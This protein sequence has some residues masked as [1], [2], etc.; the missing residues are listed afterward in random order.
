MGSIFSYSLGSGIF[1]LA[2]FI[3]YRLLLAS[4]KQPSLNRAAL[5]GLYAA[6]LLALPAMTLARQAS[7]ALP[8]SG[9]PAVN[10]GDIAIA[11]AGTP[12][13]PSVL[14]RI[15]LWTYLAGAAAILLHT[16]VS[17]ARLA[18]LIRSGRHIPRD[19]YTLVTLPGDIVPFSFAGYIVMSEADALS[20]NSMITAHELGH[21]R[22]RHWLDLLLAQGVCA[23]MWYNPAAWLARRELRRVHEYQADTAVLDRGAN[24]RAYQ[25]L[26]IEKAAGVRLQSIANSLDHSNLSKRITMMYKQTN[27]LSGRLRALALAPA[28]LLA[29]AAVN[30]PAVASALSAVSETTLAQAK[31]A[32]KSAPTK[33]KVVSGDKSTEKTDEPQNAV[34]QIPEYPGG[35]AA[36]MRFLADNIRYPEAAMKANAQGRVVVKFVVKADGTVADPE[37][38][39]GQTPELD[40]EALRV[41]GTMPA[42]TPGRDEKGNAVNCYFTL[43]VSFALQGDEPAKKSAPSTP[44]TPL[45]QATCP[46]PETAGQ[47]MSLS[48]DG[49]TIESNSSKPAININNPRYA[50]GAE[51]APAYFVNGEPFTGKIDQIRPDQIKAITVMKDDPAYPDGKILIELK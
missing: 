44:S 20:A 5:L 26:L 19:G 16:I 30:S 39:R 23:L 17:V 10:F 3:V 1:L 9:T 21:L 27:R 40:A 42:W 48:M 51:G 31:E 6:S 25:M 8:A 38:V 36:M 11:M 37:I 7:P 45:T 12:R 18:L 4:E 28:I 35:M 13:R 34:A 43:P 22:H 29:A 47:V 14:P 32:T 24:L 46:A 2:G 33:L 15:L 50:P 41:V 49:M